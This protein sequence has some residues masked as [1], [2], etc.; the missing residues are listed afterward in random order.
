MKTSYNLPNNQEL[1]KSDSVKDLG[2]LI[3]DNLTWRENINT[4]TT[5]ATSYANWILRTIRS[6][7]SEAMLTM[8]RGYVLSRL[9][10][11]SAVWSPAL[12]FDITQVE[13]VQRTYTSIIA[14]ME[15]KNYWQRLSAL[16]L[17][18]LQ[19][20]RERFCFLLD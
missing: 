19:R 15:D 18:S 20:R 6:R 16:K 17:Y 10:Y 4:L 1:T 8:Y 14:G 7:E 2:T 12:L 9:E 5:N 11:N 13:A 3:S